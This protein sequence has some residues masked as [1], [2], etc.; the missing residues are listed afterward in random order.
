MQP[1]RSNIMKPHIQSTKV[2]QKALAALIVASCVAAP[3]TRAVDLIAIA[4]ISGTYADFATETSGP[5]ENGAPGNRL[6]GIGSGITYLGGT[7]FLALP[8]RGPNASLYNA[9]IEDTT[10]YIPRF[11]P[12]TLSLAASRDPVTGLPF[13][14][15]P[16]LLDTTLLSSPLPL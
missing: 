15:T 14:L 11:Q 6:C 8:D 10:S 5:L 2:K 13:T 7:T 12:F 3:S 16:M 9:L 4:P 1:L